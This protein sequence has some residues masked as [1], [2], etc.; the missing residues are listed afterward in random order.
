MLL[1]R[2]AQARIWTTRRRR[3]DTMTNDDALVHIQITETR[4]ASSPHLHGALAA[5]NHLLYV[6]AVLLFAAT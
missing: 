4:L 2:Y 3:L 1:R 5:R 6:E